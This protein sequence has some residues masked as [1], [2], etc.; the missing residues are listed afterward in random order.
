MGSV[1]RK[2]GLP[3]SFSHLLAREG[4]LTIYDPLSPCDRGQSTR[5]LISPGV[6]ILKTDAT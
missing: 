2:T 1:P 6:I 3:M 5:T 4:L